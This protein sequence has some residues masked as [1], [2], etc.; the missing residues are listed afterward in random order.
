M[1]TNLLHFITSEILLCNQLWQ[2][3]VD[4]CHKSVLG[5]WLDDRDAYLKS[6]VR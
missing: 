5:V 2:W 6:A 3:L 4:E 1:V